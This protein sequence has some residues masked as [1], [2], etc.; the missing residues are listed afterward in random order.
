[1]LL[2]PHVPRNP[3][4]K[5]RSSRPS[6][7]RPSRS[8]GSSSRAYAAPWLSQG[9]MAMMTTMMMQRW[10]RQHMAT[11]TTTGDTR[12]GRMPRQLPPRRRQ[13]R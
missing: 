9:S 3:D 6:L 2:I 10:R 5:L 12:Q 7:E 11:T 1:M 13:R 4:K 8:S